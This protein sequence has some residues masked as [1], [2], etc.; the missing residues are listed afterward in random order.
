MKFLVHLQVPGYRLEQIPV[1]DIPVNLGFKATCLVQGDL[2]SG[3]GNAGS[4]D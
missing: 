3:Y 1:R 4:V 2:E